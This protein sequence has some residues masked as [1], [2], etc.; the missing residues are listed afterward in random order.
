MLRTPRLTHSVCLSIIHSLNSQADGQVMPWITQQS[1]ALVMHFPWCGQRLPFVFPGIFPLF[2]LHFHRAFSATRCNFPAPRRLTHVSLA[3]TDDWIDIMQFFASIVL[4]QSV[5]GRTQ[6]AGR[7][8]VRWHQIAA[9]DYQN[10]DRARE[11]CVEKYKRE[12]E[13]VQRCASLFIRCPRKH[14]WG[15]VWNEIF[16][17]YPQYH[18]LLNGRTKDNG[19]TDIQRPTEV[20]RHKLQLQDNRGTCFVKNVQPMRATNHWKK[21]WR[22]SIRII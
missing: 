10:A 11:L 6:D 1:A 12:K 9:A 15:E 8:I 22:S 17:R 19:I 13:K 5:G 7:C 2:S 20:E 14:V 18:C 3:G 21:I 16:C 4:G